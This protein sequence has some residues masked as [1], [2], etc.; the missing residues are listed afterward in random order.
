MLTLWHTFPM[1]CSFHN[2]QNIYSFLIL[3]NQW[4]LSLASLVAQMVKYLPAVWE[5]WVR[6]LGWEM[7]QRKGTATH[8][9]ILAW[10]TPWRVE[11]GR[12]QFMGSQRVGHEWNELALTHARVLLIIFCIIVKN[13]CLTFYSAL[14]FITMFSLSFSH[15]VVSNSLQPHG[16]QHV[17]LPCPSLPRRVCSDSCSLSWWCHPT[18]STPVIPFSSALNLSQHQGLF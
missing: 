12:L 1:L 6:S 2:T 17:R 14:L 5:T 4:I 3:L 18:I 8:S 11:P 10:R 15:S 9:S 7:P 16:L 13:P